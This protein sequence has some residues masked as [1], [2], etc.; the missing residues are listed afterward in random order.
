MISILF[1]SPRFI[2]TSSQFCCYT[3]CRIV[4][5]AQSKMKLCSGQLKVKIEKASFGMDTWPLLIIIFCKFAIAGNLDI[6]EDI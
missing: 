4:G 3:S 6:F 2:G 5:H 1:F